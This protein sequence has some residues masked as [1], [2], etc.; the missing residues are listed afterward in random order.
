MLDCRGKRRDR[1]KIKELNG[2]GEGQEKV[3][4]LGLSRR[5]T[6]IL[7]GVLNEINTVIYLVETLK[8]MQT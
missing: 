3:E 8:C 7:R 5:K 2:V 1:K 4:V 6:W